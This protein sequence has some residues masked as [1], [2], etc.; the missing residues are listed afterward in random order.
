MAHGG[1]EQA[2]I[3]IPSLL[4]VTILIFFSYR[5]WKSG[6]SSSSASSSG[7]NNGLRFTAAQVEQISAMFPQLS[8]RDIMWDLHRNRGSVQATTERVL[9]G[10][11]LDPVCG[12]V[13]WR[14]RRSTDPRPQAPPSFQ[15]AI[16][17]ATASTSSGASNS[18]P[19]KQEVDLITRYNLQSKISDKGK[20]KEE[21]APVPGW[22]S[23]KSERA[24]M[25]QRRREEMIL[26]ARKKMMEKDTAQTAPS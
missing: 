23:D 9:M 21:P 22:Q 2:T 10:R 7:R 16:T 19:K 8:R 1:E 17:F 3:S 18:A 13:R 5:W 25:L 20:E 26:A 4:F 24:K 11:S 6:S 12:H 14:R 15:P